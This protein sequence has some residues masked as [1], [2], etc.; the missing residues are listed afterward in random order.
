MAEDWEAKF[1]ALVHEMSSISSDMGIYP[2]SVKGYN[3]ERDYTQR[4]GFKNGW[5]AA[6]IEYGSALAEAAG[7]AAQGMDED[8]Q[9]LLAA[10]VGWLTD[11]VLHLNMNDTWA[12]A[13]A[14]SEEVPATDVAAV[15]GLFRRWGWPGIVYWVSERHQGQR[16]A[17][18]DINRF[19]DFVRHEEELRKVEPSS[20]KRAYK[21]ITY[22]LGTV[23]E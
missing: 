13:V 16:S 21:A 14:D 1:H 17:F 11:G 12:W 5:N 22:T 6:V 18:K 19:I 9:V 7:R 10:D 15:A 4:D 8:L 2:Q 20:S 3:D 23:A